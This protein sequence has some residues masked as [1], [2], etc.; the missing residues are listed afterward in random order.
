[1]SIF[2]VVCYSILIPWFRIMPLWIQYLMVYNIKQ[3]QFIILHVFFERVIEKNENPKSSYRASS[4][5][6]QRLRFRK[7]GFLRSDRSIRTSVFLWCR[8]GSDEYHAYCF[9]CRKEFG[10]DKSHQ[11]Q[12]KQ[13]SET[14]THKK[15]SKSF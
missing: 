12:L 1:M 6:N 7:I 11:L 10:C 13:H 4:C 2:I 5:Q 8:K 3:V 14:Q 15:N 9:I